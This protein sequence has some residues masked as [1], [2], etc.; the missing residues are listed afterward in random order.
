M[1]RGFQYDVLL[2]GAAK[3]NAMVRLLPEQAEEAGRQLDP[4]DPQE[5]KN[6]I[7]AAFQKEHR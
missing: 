2:R 6:K 3:D 4:R 7:L 1:K 5:A